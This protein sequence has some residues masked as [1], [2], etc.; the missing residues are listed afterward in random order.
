MLTFYDGCW[1]QGKQG[2]H[3]SLA[4]TSQSKCEIILPL[5][6]TRQLVYSPK[7]QIVSLVSLHLL[8]SPSLMIHPHDKEL[9]KTVGWIT[10]PTVPLKAPPFLLEAI[11]LNRLRHFFN[12]V[13]FSSSFT[14]AQL[15]FGAT[16][17][18]QATHMNLLIWLPV[19]AC[20]SAIF[21]LRWKETLLCWNEYVHTAQC[22]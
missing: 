9:E 4:A 12:I 18:S 15:D 2:Q 5:W 19:E 21:A 8:S 17:S 16:Q 22:P 1:N 20:M 13:I 7:Q 3:W 10:S 14:F 11:C 6:R